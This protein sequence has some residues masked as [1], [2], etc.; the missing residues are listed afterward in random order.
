M[1]EMTLQQEIILF[2]GELNLHI[3]LR[4]TTLQDILTDKTLP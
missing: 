4:L 2:L 1:N 3:T